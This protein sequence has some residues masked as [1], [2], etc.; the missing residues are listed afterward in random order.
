MASSSVAWGIE[1]GAGAI[2]AVKLAAEGDGAKCLEFVVIPHA[3]PTSAP[4][5]DFNEVV[6][7]SLSQLA[8]QFDLSGATIAV[9][10]PGHAGFARFAK[11]P[12]VDPKKVPDIV[13]FEA[14]QQIPFPLEQ[15]EW[16]F[17]T[18]VSPDSPDIEVGIFAITR[19]RIMERLG[20]L[21]VAGL[22]PDVVTL[23]PLAA[24][25]AL[26]FDLQMSDKDTGTV[27]VDIGTTSTDLVVSEAGRV[28]VRTFPIGGHQ[29][30][31]ELAN[32]FKLPYSKA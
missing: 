2:K 19:E 9:S 5:T 25:N 7:L 8:S 4:G 15:V 14:M 31:L 6:A 11:L 24:F 10:V 26:A 30:T 1:V 27:I 28:W 18:F 17:Q 32:T 16:D 22:T 21:E 20:M 3:R 23:S 29:F 13:K 12:P